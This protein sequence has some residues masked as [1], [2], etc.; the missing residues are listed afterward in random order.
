MAFH[1]NAKLKDRSTQE[2]ATTVSESEEHG[3]RSQLCPLEAARS[4]F[5]AL[6]H[7]TSLE[8]P[9]LHID[10]PNC[11]LRADIVRCIERALQKR[12][13]DSADLAE[14]A[15]NYVLD[16]PPLIG[17]EEFAHSLL[18]CNEAR[19]QVLENQEAKKPIT[20][21][22]SRLLAMRKKGLLPC[23]RPGAK[24]PVPATSSQEV[25]WYHERAMNN[26]HISLTDTYIPLK[27][28]DITKGNEGRS[29][30]V[31]YGPSLKLP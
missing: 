9:E 29:W 16:H 11:I 28:T 14:V 13:L 3:P 24:A 12:T 8:I 5:V 23:D 1:L 30:S 21:S 26:T 2:G 19:L 27:G 6:S 10:A 7:E 4:S 25:G 31:Y 17:W 22:R 18:K 20:R 15:Q